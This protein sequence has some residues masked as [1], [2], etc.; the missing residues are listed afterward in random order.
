MKIVMKVFLFLATAIVVIFVIGS[1]LNVLIPAFQSL[2]D[3][4]QR[5]RSVKEMKQIIEA[6]NN[7]TN[8][9][10]SKH[11][12]KSL[13]ELN[14]E[15][16]SISVFRTRYW[17][18]PDLVSNSTTNNRPILI[19]KP[20]HYKR[21]KGGYIAYPEGIY[22]FRFGEDYQNIIDVYIHGTKNESIIK[23]RW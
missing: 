22:Q 19:E 13:K 21:S 9:N 17:Y 15:D 20:D 12:P 1:V 16:S 6:L 3:K 10:P 23:N 2:P 7:Y 4:Q 5:Q 11:Y 8:K 18:L 14:I